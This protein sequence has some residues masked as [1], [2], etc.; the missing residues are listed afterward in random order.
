LERN[1]ELKNT[2]C[3]YANKQQGPRCAGLPVCAMIVAGIVGSITSLATEIPTKVP[4]D[5][6]NRSGLG[7][8]W[9]RRQAVAAL[10]LEIIDHF[11]FVLIAQSRVPTYLSDVDQMDRPAPAA[12]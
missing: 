5:D 1:E 11:G 8:T 2:P 9:R 12:A 10:S 4:G 3:I 6:R 7:D